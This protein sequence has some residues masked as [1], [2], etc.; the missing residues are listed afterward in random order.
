MHSPFAVMI[1]LAMNPV[2]TMAVGST[3][4]RRT[5]QEA[6]KM[7]IK[8]IMTGAEKMM[9]GVRV[10]MKRKEAVTPKVLMIGKSARTK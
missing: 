2:M 3:A 6:R 10:I 9:L 7:K 8:R 1:S 5:R 4:T